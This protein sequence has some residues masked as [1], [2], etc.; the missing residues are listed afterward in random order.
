LLDAI[1]DFKHGDMEH[2]AKVMVVILP[3]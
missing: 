1:H 3:Q 2:G